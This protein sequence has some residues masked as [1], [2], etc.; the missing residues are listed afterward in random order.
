[1]GLNRLILGCQDA[2]DEEASLVSLL[3]S[4]L[5]LMFSISCF[6]VKAKEREQTPRRFS[7]QSRNYEDIHLLCFDVVCIGIA[8]GATRR[9]IRKRSA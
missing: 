6:S 7:S 1:M 4:L 3:I 8:Y 9:H 5:L 2:S